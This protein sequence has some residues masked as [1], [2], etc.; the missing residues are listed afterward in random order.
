MLVRHEILLSSEARNHG[1][2]WVEE[3]SEEIL[4]SDC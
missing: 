1:I 4:P 2:S 3:A